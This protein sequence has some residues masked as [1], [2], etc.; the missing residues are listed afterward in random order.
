MSAANGVIQAI[1][2]NPALVGAERICAP[3]RATKSATTW[4]A[5][6]PRVRCSAISRRIASAVPHVQTRTVRSEQPQ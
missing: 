6:S 1:R 3:Y 4:S 5:V 2:S